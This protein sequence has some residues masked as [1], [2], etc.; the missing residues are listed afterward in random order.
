MKKKEVSPENIFPP[1]NFLIGNFLIRKFKKPQCLKPSIIDTTPFLFKTR[2]YICFQMAPA[3]T[4]LT[5]K[6]YSPS[7]CSYKSRKDK[8]LTSFK[9][10][11]VTDCRYITSVHYTRMCG[12]GSN[13]LLTGGE[14]AE[15]KLIQN[16]HEIQRRKQL[17][18]SA[19][20]NTAHA[21]SSSRDG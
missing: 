7:K 15:K 17:S 1:R 8:N 16:D 4:T 10:P 5:F 19:T 20:K 18:K 13:R 2:S 3:V 21:N 6:F 12:K 14:R 9:S 11:Y